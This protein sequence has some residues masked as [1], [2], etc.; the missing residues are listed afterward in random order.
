MFV[1]TLLAGVNA[2]AAVFKLVVTVLIDCVWPEM[3]CAEKYYLLHLKLNQLYSHCEVLCLLKI[4]FNNI[5]ALSAFSNDQ[6]CIYHFSMNT[7][8]RQNK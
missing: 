8:Q 4:M 3:P 1:E 2:T 7:P 6:E 5:L